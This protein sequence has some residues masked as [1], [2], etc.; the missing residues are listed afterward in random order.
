MF[1]PIGDEPNLRG[2]PWVT[3]LLIAANVGVFGLVTW[4]ASSQPLDPT[5]PATAEYLRF[6]ASHLSRAQLRGLKYRCR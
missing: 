6:L 2:I 4:P 3:W 5:D 1:L